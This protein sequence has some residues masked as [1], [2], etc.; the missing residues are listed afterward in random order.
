M[1]NIFTDCCSSRYPVTE[2]DSWWLFS[3]VLSVVTVS[4]I[5]PLFPFAF[6]AYPFY[7]YVVEIWETWLRVF[8]ESS[9]MKNSERYWTGFTSLDSV[10][11]F[12]VL[13]IACF[14]RIDFFYVDIYC[15]YRFYVC[16]C[17]VIGC[18][19]MEDVVVASLSFVGWYLIIYIVKVLMFFVEWNVKMSD[20]CASFCGLFSLP[21]WLRFLHCSTFNCTIVDF[22][23]LFLVCV[24]KQIHWIVLCKCV[25]LLVDCINR[26]L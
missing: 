1:L 12:S 19:E 17:V 20:Y 9:P 25:I 26:Q 3:S 11:V 16:F 23:S 5:F 6:V 24:V 21:A 13:I 8:I 22:I 2:N 4:C 14:W 18:W 7:S 10:Q 15:F